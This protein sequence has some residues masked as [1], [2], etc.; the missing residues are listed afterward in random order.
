[1]K[2]MMTPKPGTDKEPGVS[3]VKAIMAE[4][5]RV[6]EAAAHEEVRV[7]KKTMRL[8]RRQSFPSLGNDYWKEN[9]LKSTII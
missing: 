2:K 1:M 8:R 5:R 7:M 4:R 3:K 6:E 9:M